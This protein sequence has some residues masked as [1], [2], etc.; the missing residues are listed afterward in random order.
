MKRRS[1]PGLVVVVA[2]WVATCACVGSVDGPA[3][4]GGETRGVDGSDADTPT[5][6]SPNQEPTPS[7]PPPASP[8]PMRVG[9]VTPVELTTFGG[10]L[11]IE[12]EHLEAATVTIGGVPCP[13]RASSAKHHAASAPEHASS[14]SVPKMAKPPRP[15]HT[16]LPQA[17]C[18]RAHPRCLHCTVR[19]E[20][21]TPSRGRQLRALCARMRGIDGLAHLL[22]HR[23][24]RRALGHGD[25][26]HERSAPAVAARKR[27]CRLRPHP[28]LS[29]W[30]AHRHTL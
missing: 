11:A 22:L 4:L 24:E 5:A 29:G 7:Q 1:L 8:E 28:S 9:L 16:A 25:G 13:V 21:K 6:S 10:D 18:R 27:P 14:R 30:P 2:G 3:D 26:G 23:R 12:G 17:D 15:S 20:W 19:P